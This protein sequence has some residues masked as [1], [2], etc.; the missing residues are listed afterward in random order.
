M[1]HTVAC[2]PAPRTPLTPPRWEIAPLRRGDQSAV[3]ELFE[4]MSPNSRWLRFLAPVPRL[5]AQALAHLSNVDG[6]RHFALAARVQ[7]RC[8]GIARAMLLRDDPTV[9]DLAVAVA[10]DHHRQGLG[11][12]LVRCLAQDARRRG[13]REFEAL[14]H[15]DNA[16]ARGLARTVGSSAAYDDGLLRLRWPLAGAPLV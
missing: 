7:G 1:T 13:V 14:V 6:Q 5:T 9:A 8:V 2:L 10:D 16:A 15:P 3:L 12:R 11:L 4:A